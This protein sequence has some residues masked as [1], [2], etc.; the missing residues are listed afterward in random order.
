M[1]RIETEQ[2]RTRYEV[3]RDTVGAKVEELTGD[4]LGRD[5]QVIGALSVGEL[6]VQLPGL[7]IDEIGGE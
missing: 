6:R 1:A 3:L 2:A 7:G 5:R 4:V